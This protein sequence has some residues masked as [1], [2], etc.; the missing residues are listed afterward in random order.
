MDLTYS[1]VP[2]ACCVFVVNKIYDGSLAADAY[3]ARFVE[4]ELGQANG[5]DNVAFIRGDRAFHFDFLE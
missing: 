3:E 4:L 2:C 1:V 5:M